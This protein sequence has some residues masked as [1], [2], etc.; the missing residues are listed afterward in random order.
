M[1]CLFASGPEL[2]TIPT[3]TGAIRNRY[4]VN[5]VEV[6][7]GPTPPLPQPGWEFHRIEAA[8]PTAASSP[9]QFQGETGAA[10]YTDP[11]AP[12]AAANG[13]PTLPA[14]AD[15]V[16]AVPIPLRKSPAWHALSFEQRKALLPAHVDVGV[17]FTKT[18]HRRLFHSRAFTK[19]YDFLT[20]FE[21]R[22]TDEPAFRQLCQALR[23][24]KRNPEWAY[25]DR[26]CEIWLTKLA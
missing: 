11:K 17:P 20:Y 18:I 5:A 10:Q 1:H 3:P 16:L 24:P 25:I 21:F 12:Y 23:D 8:T 15:P 13:L 9:V 14:N 4:R 6:L 7:K 19:D 2:I 22:A 26:D